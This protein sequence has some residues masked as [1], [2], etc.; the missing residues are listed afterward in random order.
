[1][2]RILLL[3]ASSHCGASWR[4]TSWV[5][6]PTV[7]EVGVQVVL[8]ACNVTHSP[9]SMLHSANGA[10]HVD[11]RFVSTSPVLTLDRAANDRDLHSICCLWTS[12]LV[13]YNV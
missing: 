5:A 13:H 4:C 12:L 8:G 10:V 6:G 3:T 1:M 11:A 9:C 2:V 7:S